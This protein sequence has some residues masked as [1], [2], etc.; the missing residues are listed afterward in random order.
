MLGRSLEMAVAGWAWAGSGPDFVL[1]DAVSDAVSRQGRE[2]FKAR[3]HGCCAGRRSLG[4]DQ[5]NRRSRWARPLKG[6]FS[7]AASDCCR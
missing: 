5:S 1:A 7:E 6:S 4:T 3:F 2:V